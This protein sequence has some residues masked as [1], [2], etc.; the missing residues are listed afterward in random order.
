MLSIHP[1]QAQTNQTNVSQTE[2]MK[3]FIGSWKIDLGKETT[4]LWECK[5][6]GTGFETYYKAVTK[7][8]ILE[9]AK[10]LCGYNKKFDT[11]IRILILN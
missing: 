6:F 8:Q 7:G 11:N 4:G 2:L 1:T 3:Q 5:L 10:E 9:E